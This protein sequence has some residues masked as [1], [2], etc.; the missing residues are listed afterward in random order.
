MGRIATSS[1]EGARQQASLTIQIGLEDN[2]AWAGDEL[3]NRHIM[4]ANRITDDYDSIVLDT[5]LV[6]DGRRLYSAGLYFMRSGA[7][8]DRTRDQT[9]Y[10]LTVSPGTLSLLR[11]E[12]GAFNASV[13]GIP[14]SMVALGL[15]GRVMTLTD[16][17]TLLA[18]EDDRQPGRGERP[19]RESQHAKG[20][21]YHRKSGG[22]VLQTGVSL[23]MG[24]LT[25]A[26]MARNDGAIKPAEYF[27][28]TAVRVNTGSGFVMLDVRA[29]DETEIDAAY[30]EYQLNDRDRFWLDPLYTLAIEGGK[31]VIE[32]SEILKLR[33]YANPFASNSAST[34]RDA[35]RS[36]SKAVGTRVAI[37][38]THEKRNRRKGRA[39]LVSS[40]RLQPVVNATIDLDRYEVTGSDGGTQEVIRDFTV[41]LQTAEPVE[42]LP[43]AK[44]ERARG[45]LTTAS[46]GDFCFESIRNLSTDDRQMWSYVMRVVRSKGLSA[47][48]LFETMWRNLELRAPSV[49]PYA[50]MDRSGRPLSAPTKDGG[51]PVNPGQAPLASPEQ[52]E[53]RKIDAVRKQ[54]TR[55]VA[56]LEKMLDEKKAA[57]ND[58]SSAIFR[59][60]SWHRDGAGRIIGVKIQRNSS[61]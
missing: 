28:D 18:S 8:T 32:G 27:K 47:T 14:V 19:S 41:N 35:L 34:M 12:K 52:V 31:T 24:P 39:K 48:I 40:M 43:L 50:Y 15:D 5:D 46:A 54:H 44:Y 26:L 37:D 61:A 53:Q 13:C 6:R 23:T 21:S 1:T 56:K 16:A 22:N 4:L 17:V 10:M 33:G 30:R 36:I 59:D 60:W 9:I 3:W 42:S 20:D 49:S 11:G 58:G 29:S 2:D 25:N 57:G 45:M 7:L 38:V 51:A 55:M